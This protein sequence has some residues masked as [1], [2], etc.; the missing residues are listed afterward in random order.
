MTA[1]SSKDKGG[2]GK[3][4]PVLTVNR[5]GKGRCVNLM[6]GHNAQSMKSLGF[7]A[8]L[9][10][11]VEWAATDSGKITSAKDT[12]SFQKTDSSIALM[13]NDKVVW[14][15]NYGKNQTKPYFHTLSLSDGP[16]LTW[17]A[18]PDHIWHYGLWFSW[19][20]INGVNYW[21][22]NRQTG[23]A[24][25]TTE[26]E[27]VEFHTYPER[28]AHITMDLTYHEP[29]KPVVLSEKR[30][31]TISVPDDS[32]AY[33]IDWRSTF[34]AVADKVELNRTP[35]PWEKNGRSWGGYAGLSFRACKDVKDVQ[36]MGT[37][38]DLVLNDGKFR[39]KDVAVEYS[40]LIND[41]VFGIAIL[42]HPENLNTPSPWY[43]IDGGPMSFFSPAV[44]CYGPHVMNKGETFELNYR[45]CIHPDRWE[46]KELMRQ[47]QM[48]TSEK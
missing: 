44:L 10:R 38:G 20:F 17:I 6:L 11:S 39:Y 7:A 23:K 40:G 8:L 21:E 29:G 30:T 22:E 37:F 46:A 45:I 3:D 24:A 19:K 48:F 15:F 26:W 35:L 41:K 33:T 1:F 27:N 16:V 18:P 31:L 36:F 28:T 4:E 42:D 12:L 2:S 9:S 43:L 47:Y 25:G 13:K 34:T 5:F 32:D 14:Q